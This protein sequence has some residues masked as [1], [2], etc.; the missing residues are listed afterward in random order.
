[1]SS[2]ERALVKYSHC[3]ADIDSSI[4]NPLLI[5]SSSAI[6]SSHPVPYHPV[7]FQTIPSNPIPSHPIP[8]H[9]IPSTPSHPTSSLFD[10]HVPSSTRSSR[11]VQPHQ[12]VQPQND[13]G[14]LLASLSEHMSTSDSLKSELAAF[15]A[16]DPAMYD[17]KR[18]AGGV[19][20]DAAHL[21][22]STWESDSPKAPRLRISIRSERDS[23][24]W[25]P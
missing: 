16:A 8:S 23:G 17:R 19:C 1:V 2:A 9:P 6:L 15:T 3:M 7:P 10:P 25:L 13:R 4:V 14:K 20:K 11:H 18:L 21:W 22:T 5:D 12:P 24:A